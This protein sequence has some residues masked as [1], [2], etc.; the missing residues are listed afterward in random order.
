MDAKLILLGLVIIVLG[1]WDM[2]DGASDF[3]FGPRRLH[4]YIRRDSHPFLF[5][6]CIM[7]Y[8]VAGAAF[9]FWGCYSSR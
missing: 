7:I 6:I 3:F 8:F 4:D 9:I 2:Q 1:V 5:W